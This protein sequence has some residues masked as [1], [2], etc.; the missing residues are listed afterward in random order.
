MTATDWWSVHDRAKA[1]PDFPAFL[2]TLTRKEIEAHIVLDSWQRN[3]FG[4]FE[5]TIGD[6]AEEIYDEIIRRGESV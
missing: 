5:G 2:R 4:L 3:S 6:R 1:A